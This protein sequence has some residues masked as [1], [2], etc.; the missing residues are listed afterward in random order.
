MLF[1]GIFSDKIN[2]VLYKLVKNIGY[3]MIGG[4]LR[5]AI[6][7]RLANKCGRN[8]YIGPYV[9]IIHIENLSIGDNVSIHAN[10]YIDCTAAVTIGNDV[11]I[12]H[13]CS[14]ISFDHTYD[15][16]DISIR[17]Q[18]LKRED[19][20]ISNNIWVGCRVCILAGVK[21]GERMICA[22]GTVVCKSFEEGHAIIGGVPAKIIRH[23]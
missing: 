14:I 9:T 18:P 1:T 11:S 10:T 22:A 20:V 13:S 6:V 3:G 12:A 2:K 16:E 7:K 8:I 4:N 21:L 15:V 17:D 19:I 5:Y 23:I